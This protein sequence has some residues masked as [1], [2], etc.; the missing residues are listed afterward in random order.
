MSA[1]RQPI[2]RRLDLLLGAQEVLAS[3]QPAPRPHLPHEQRRP[4]AVTQNRSTFE[5]A[6]NISRSNSEALLS[7][8][9]KCSSGRPRTRPRSWSPMR[10]TPHTTRT[11]KPEEQASFSSPAP[12]SAV[13]DGLSSGGAE[14]IRTPDLLNAIQAA[15]PDQRAL[16]HRT[17][18]L[19]NLWGKEQAD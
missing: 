11:Q 4:V 19:Y 17:C 16:L 2:E 9:P 10:E 8:M 7:T 1:F 14:G 5:K 18:R 15:N 13:Y 3:V 12:R 6:A